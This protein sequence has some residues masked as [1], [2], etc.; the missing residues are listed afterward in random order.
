[1]FHLKQRPKQ[2]QHS[3]HW[4]EVFSE[5]QL[6]KRV[7]SNHSHTTTA[8]EPQTLAESI[9]TACMK[10]LGFVGEAETTAVE[11]CKKVEHWLADK[12]EVTSDDIKRQAAAALRKYNPRAAYEYL[13]VEEYRVH[14]DQYG[15]I[16]L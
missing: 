15:F 12:D 13:P 1:M 16:Q 6:E 4:H 10:T 9:H 7:I 2:T 14:E 5:H 11:V 3:P 8:Y